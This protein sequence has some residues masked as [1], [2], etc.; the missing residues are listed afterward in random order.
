MRA[1][2]ADIKI[3]SRTEQ[4]SEEQIE[5]FWAWRAMTE[6]VFRT[7]DIPTGERFEYWHDLMVNTVG[8]MEIKS[9]AAADFQAEMRIV[10]LGRLVVWPTS[11]AALKWTRS[12]H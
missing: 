10:Q 5:R 7:D 6:T 2:E 1:P 4:S 9:P 8:P 12:P 3:I 11:L